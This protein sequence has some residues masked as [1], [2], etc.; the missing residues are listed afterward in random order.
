MVEGAGSHGVPERAHGAD[1]V[2]LEYRP[3]TSDFTAAVWAQFRVSPDRPTVIWGL[4]AFVASGCSSAAVSWSAGHTTAVVIRLGGTFFFV[5]A[6]WSVPVSWARRLQRL[7]EP[8]GTVHMT[9][10]DAGVTATTDKGTRVRRWGARHRYRETRTVFVVLG[11]DTTADAPTLLPKRAVRTPEDI[12]R[13]RAILDRNM[14]R[15]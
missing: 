7:A 11:S 13:L 2:E 5:A 8:H 3:R 9:V 15:V 4:V 12:D 14:T 10:T 1:A 6:A